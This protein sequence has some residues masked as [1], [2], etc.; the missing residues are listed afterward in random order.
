MG[1][2]AN[3]TITI[4]RW[5]R[6]W[7]YSD[8]LVVAEEAKGKGLLSVCVLRGSVCIAIE[9]HSSLL[10]RYYCHA[11]IGLMTRKISSILVCRQINMHMSGLHD[12]TMAFASLFLGHM[13]SYWQC[14][15]L[16]L[17]AS[18]P[19]MFQCLF[20]QFNFI[21]LTLLCCNIHTQNIC[22]GNTC[23]TFH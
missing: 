13:C 4:F 16:S 7:A 8:K 14:L 3:G 2:N 18:P 21:S 11:M 10:I 5:Q 15:A 9:L 12:E 1:R 19:P 6:L 22:N 20:L 23:L 17:F